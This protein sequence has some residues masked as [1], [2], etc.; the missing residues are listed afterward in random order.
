MKG[1]KQLSLKLVDLKVGDRLLVDTFAGPKV[2]MEVVHIDRDWAEGCLIYKKDLER[3]KKAGVPYSK[4]DVPR[5]CRGVIFED[6]II[7]KVRKRRKRNG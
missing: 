7:K 6:Q 1:K 3:L 4:D 5:K 2:T